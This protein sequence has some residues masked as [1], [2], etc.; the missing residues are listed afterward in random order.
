MKSIKILTPDDE[1]F[2]YFFPIEIDGS[3]AGKLFLTYEYPHSSA[4]KLLLYRSDKIISDNQDKINFKALEQLVRNHLVSGK[5]NIDTAKALVNS[6]V[7]GECNI[8]NVSIAIDRYGPVPIY[9]L[10][11]RYTVSFNHKEINDCEIGIYP[12]QEFKKY[13][14]SNQTIGTTNPFEFTLSLSYNLPL[15]FLRYFE[16]VAEYFFD[17]ENHS[18]FI[19]TFQKLN[20]ADIVLAESIEEKISLFFKN[21]NGNNDVILATQSLRSE[22]LKQETY[23]ILKAKFYKNLSYFLINEMY[24]I[25]GA[26]VKD[27]KTKIVDLLENDF[28]LEELLNEDGHF[29]NLF[30]SYTEYLSCISEKKS[31]QPKYKADKDNWIGRYIDFMAFL[32]NLKRLSSRSHKSR[33]FYS[34]HHDIPISEFVREKLSDFLS[35]S[36]QDKIDLISVSN[37]RPNDPIKEVIKAGIWISDSTFAILPKDTK[38]VNNIDKDYKWITREGCHT[39]L[40]KKKLY[41]LKEDG[42]NEQ[43]IIK[44]FKDDKINFLSP[45]ARNH[46]RNSELVQMYQDNLL[47]VFN[48]HTFRDLD[49][50][51][52]VRLESLLYEIHKERIK[53]VLIAWLNR[54]S[55]VMAKDIVR[56]NKETKTNR[57]GLKKV[58]LA[59]RLFVNDDLGLNS[60]KRKVTS[61]YNKVKKRTY[62]IDGN[63]FLLI[64]KSNDHYYSGG[65]AELI[66][67]LFPE[68]TE[69]TIFEILGSIYNKYQI[70]K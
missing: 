56:I 40:L 63:E 70:L 16:D 51:L 13:N 65:M 5:R 38:S 49:E 25:L 69:E 44:D 31:F 54:F 58:T 47:I 55:C 53:S 28:P 41:F 36:F 39:L 37:L 64:K 24:E 26:N 67:G 21:L 43:L 61:I 50:N 33:I 8:P 15:L 9:K 14:K 23:T 19:M 59:N 34:F 30:N 17:I 18:D 60:A 66:T 3:S 7:T 11:E 68:A 4:R 48:Q 35:T 42:A 6:I 10:K 62:L 52:K 32:S 27:Y 12:Y 22:I 46:Q 45:K 2:G 29:N 20:K 57:K 1:Q